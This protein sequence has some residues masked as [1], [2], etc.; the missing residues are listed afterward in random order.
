MKKRIF[1]GLLGIA[2]FLFAGF[3][4]LWSKSLFTI[5]ESMHI[6]VNFPASENIPAGE[7]MSCCDLGSPWERAFGSEW[8]EYPSG[9]VLV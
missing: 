6:S 1:T 5:S 3:I 7:K 9:G 2:G 8:N 4:G